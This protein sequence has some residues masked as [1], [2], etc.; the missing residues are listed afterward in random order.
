MPYPE[1][2]LHPNEELVLDLHPHWW[3]ITP[4]MVALA[5][6]IVF[7]IWAL[8][9][10]NDAVRWIAAVAVIATLI[11]EIIAWRICREHQES[12]SGRAYHCSCISLTRP[13][14]RRLKNQ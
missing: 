6:A 4:S 3:T 12:C 9:F 13:G 11:R 10:D 1:D 5:G 8:T 2:T 14:S 7:G